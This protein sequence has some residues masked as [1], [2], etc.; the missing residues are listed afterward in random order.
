MKKEKISAGGIALISGSILLLVTMV[1]HPQGE[2]LEHL[3]DISTAIIVTHGIAII[4]V[5]ISLYGFWECHIFLDGS[6]FL[7]RIALVTVSLS[8]LSMMMAGVLNGLVLLFFL[9]NMEK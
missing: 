6:L 4:S 7:S 8:L 3:R 5:P 2:S 9:K 1:F